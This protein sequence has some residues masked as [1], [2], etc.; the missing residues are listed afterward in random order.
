MSDVLTVSLETVFEAIP[1]G[2]GLV[3]ASRRIVLMNR[4]FRDTLGLQ[5][6]AFPTGTP[7]E[8]AVWP[9]S[10]PLLKS[11]GTTN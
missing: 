6:D 9:T 7:M 2:L 5:P 11:A 10:I 3:D 8:E 4:A 1:V